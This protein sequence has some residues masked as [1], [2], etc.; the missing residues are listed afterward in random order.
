MNIL[1]I[2]R[3]HLNHPSNEPILALVAHLTNKS[4]PTSF[5]FFK[6]FSKRF[7]QPN[8][9]SQFNLLGV[10]MINNNKNSIK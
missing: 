3:L 9:L 10:G 6:L 5:L 1:H 7:F 2:L 4:K 8:Y